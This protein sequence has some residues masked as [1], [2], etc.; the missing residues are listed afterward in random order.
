MHHPQILPGVVQ[1]SRRPDR[2]PHGAAFDG[3]QRPVAAHPDRR[4]E[5]DGRRRPR[6][7][8]APRE[9]RDQGALGQRAQHRRRNRRHR[10]P[11]ERHTAGEG[12][13][14][15]PGDEAGARDDADVGEDRRARETRRVPAPRQPDVR[16]AADGRAPGKPDRRGPVP[17]HPGHRRSLRPDDQPGAGRQRAER[18]EV[19]LRVTVER[20][21]RP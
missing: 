13:P 15:R 11:H 8:V 4:G 5:A 19:R 9:H 16:D 6:G 10:R 12:A 2:L 1:D 18:R 17:L 20:P 21:S 14:C 7:A 3:R